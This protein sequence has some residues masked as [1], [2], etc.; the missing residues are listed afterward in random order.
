MSRSVFRV[1]EKTECAVGWDDPLGTFFGQ[2]YKVD[3]EGERVEEDE[4]GNDGTILWVGTK[5]AEIR[6]VDE[7]ARRL[8]PHAILTHAIH[9]ELF[10][11]ECD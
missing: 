7:L 2:I 1:D 10:S 8:L 4:D 3:Q 9:A 6:T 11:I 5:P